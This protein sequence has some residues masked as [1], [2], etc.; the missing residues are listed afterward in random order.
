MSVTWLSLWALAING[1]RLFE[2]Q[3]LLNMGHDVDVKNQRGSTPLHFA[4]KAG[5]T[6]I[7]RMLLDSGAD[8][9][10]KGRDGRTA[11]HRAAGDG[12]VAVAQ[13]LLDFGAD[14]LARDQDERTPEDFAS[15]R[16]QARVVALLRTARAEHE[17]AEAFAIMSQDTRLGA[18]SPFLLLDKESHL[19][20]WCG[21]A[22]T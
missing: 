22:L 6:A 16:G 13:V 11:L 12:H 17:S 7:V 5:R 15:A 8:I 4:A 21:S 9:H 1:G 2:V 20:Q 18:E 14:L 3:W 10:L 19:H